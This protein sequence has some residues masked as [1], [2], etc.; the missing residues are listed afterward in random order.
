[1]RAK[2]PIVPVDFVRSEGKGRSCSYVG[3]AAYSSCRF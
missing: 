3:K 1:M 2:Q